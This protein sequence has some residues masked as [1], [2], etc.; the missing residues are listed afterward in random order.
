MVEHGLTRKGARGW[1]FGLLDSLQFHGHRRGFNSP[2]PLQFSRFHSL[3]SGPV[4]DAYE[5]LAGTAGACP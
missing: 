3:V 5:A 2:H 4:D 1:L